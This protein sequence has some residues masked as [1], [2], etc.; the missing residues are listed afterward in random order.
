MAILSS[1][2]FLSQLSVE[3]TMTE[4]PALGFS[5]HFFGQKEEALSWL[6]KE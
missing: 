6:L 3:Q 5:S 4:N 1:P 2:D